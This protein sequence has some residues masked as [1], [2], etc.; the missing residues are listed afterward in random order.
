[1]LVLIPV[2]SD[3]FIAYVLDSEEDRQ[4]LQASLGVEIITSWAYFRSGEVH[5]ETADECLNKRFRDFV[6]SLAELPSGAA[7]SEYTR[8]ALVACV[9]DFVTLPT[10]DRLLRL[11]EEEYT[12]YRLAERK[13][14]EPDVQRLFRSIDDFLKTASK[15]LN[16]RKSRAGRSL[17]N[18]VEYLLSECGIP[19]VSRPRVDKTT[20]DILI[21]GDKAYMDR[22]YPERK[23]LMLAIKRTCKDRWRQITREAPRIKTKHLLTMQEGVSESQLNE[24]NSAKVT[25]VVPSSLH[26]TYARRLRKKLLTVEQFIDYAAKTVK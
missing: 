5:P 23:L 14:Y 12:L 15:I 20:P 10:D 9:S 6:D 1:V 26:K 16:G 13:I 11:M 22:T 17:E 7:F 2:D 24:M 3:N 25:L 21:P 8:N 18:H 19:F 4:D